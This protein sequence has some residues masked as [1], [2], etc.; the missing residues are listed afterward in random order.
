MWVK[1]AKSIEKSQKFN[2]HLKWKDDAKRARSTNS[3][4]RWNFCVSKFWLTVSYKTVEYRLFT[5]VESYVNIIV[6]FTKQ[7]HQL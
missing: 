5:M 6:Q 3:N 2:F 4:Y 1:R 7:L